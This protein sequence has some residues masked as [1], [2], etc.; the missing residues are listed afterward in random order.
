MFQVSFCIVCLTVLPGPLD[1]YAIP[2]YAQK[3]SAIALTEYAWRH[4]I[5]RVDE[6]VA[7]IVQLSLGRPWDVLERE[8]VW[9]CLLN[10]GLVGLSE[11]EVE[12]NTRFFHDCNLLRPTVVNAPAI[13]WKDLYKGYVTELQR[14]TAEED[15]IAG[16]SA[17]VNYAADLERVRRDQ[18]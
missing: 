3:P 9:Q 5:A 15:L 12:G 7:V 17:D 10:G 14:V 16:L 8:R 2:S 11:K 18:S 13:F 6:E 4:R 1:A